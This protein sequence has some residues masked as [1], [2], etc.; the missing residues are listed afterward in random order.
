[1]SIGRGKLCGS[2][3]R[4]SVACLFRSPWMAAFPSTRG[5]VGVIAAPVM[6]GLGSNFH[7]GRGAR[8]GAK[9]G[10]DNEAADLGGPLDVGVQE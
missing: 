1:M 10:E 6:S 8:S 9:A 7:G 3:V 4:R 2:W 5:G